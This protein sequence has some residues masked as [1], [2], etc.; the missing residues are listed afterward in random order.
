M[1]RIL[2]RIRS[3]NVRK[4]L[5]TADELGLVYTHEAWGE[6]GLRLDSESFTKLN[7]NRL[8][9][10]LVDGDFVLWE[11]HAICR[12]LVRQY[13][14][15]VLNND[16]LRAAAWVDQWLDWQQ[17]TLN[18]AWRDAFLGLVRQHPAHRSPALIHA[19]V[20]LWSETMQILE[21]TLS[22]G[23][24]FLV[25]DRFSIADISVGLSIHRWLQTPIP[26]EPLPFVLAY[27]EAL[28]RRQKAR[29]YLCVELA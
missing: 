3:I 15:G 24:R 22:D 27:Y 23:R 18:P 26:R 29:P 6:G 13:D 11:S 19:S 2:G 20:Q 28:K 4:V 14:A 1:I 9:P 21:Q 25:G 16:N 12:H 17:S 8:V 10:V 5:W 7:P